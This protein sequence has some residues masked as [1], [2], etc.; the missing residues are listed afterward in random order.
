MLLLPL[1][2]RLAGVHP[3]GSGFFAHQAEHFWKR[4]RG[5]WMEF[6]LILILRPVGG[7]VLAELWCRSLSCWLSW[8]CSTCWSFLGR[9]SWSCPFGDLLL[10]IDRVLQQRCLTLS[11]FLRL[12]VMLMMTWFFMVGLEGRVSL[13]M[14]LLSRLLTLDGG[15]SVLLS[16]MFVLTCLGFMVPYLI[17]FMTISRPV[18]NHDGVG[19]IS[20][21]CLVWSGGSEWFQV[22]V[23]VICAED[24]LFG[25]TPW[26]LVKWVFILEES[27]LASWGFG[28]GCWWRLL[29]GC[30]FSLS[31]VGW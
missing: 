24:V 9:L 16:L 20:L 29:W 6:V 2:D 19:G 1:F 15:E 7:F 13:E 26:S 27:S 31:C 12:R 5:M 25:L 18:V 10:L 4:R 23:T 28:S 21:D 22:P 30:L 14:M 11:V 8:C 17:V 3:S